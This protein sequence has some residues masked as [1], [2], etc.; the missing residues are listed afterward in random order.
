[1]LVA[2]RGIVFYWRDVEWPA[3]RAE[4]LHLALELPAEESM[5]AATESQDLQRFH[6]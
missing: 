1:V 3:Q 6:N 2:S 4:S 5:I